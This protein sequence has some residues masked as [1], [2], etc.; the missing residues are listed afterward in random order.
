EP[1]PSVAVLSLTYGKKTALR[2]LPVY[3]ELSGKILFEI[4]QR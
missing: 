3:A 2:V 1:P 4:E